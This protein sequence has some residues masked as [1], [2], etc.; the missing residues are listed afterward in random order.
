MYLRLT[1]SDNSISL[2]YSQPVSALQILTAE[3]EW[4]WVKHV[5]GAGMSQPEEW[6][7]IKG[8]ADSET[9]VV[10]TADALDCEVVVFGVS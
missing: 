4:K 8:H 1:H 6:I 7:T 10:N 2:L 9:V 5:D 3:N